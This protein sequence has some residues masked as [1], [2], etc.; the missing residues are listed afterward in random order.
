[1]KKQ[2]TFESESAGEEVWYYWK[3]Q[4]G[5]AVAEETLSKGGTATSAKNQ[6]AGTSQVSILQVQ[7]R[8]DSNDVFFFSLCLSLYEILM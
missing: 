4:L 8:W 1:M 7:G 5:K 3:S 2:V 6:E